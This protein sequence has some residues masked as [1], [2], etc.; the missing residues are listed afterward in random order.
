MSSPGLSPGLSLE[1]ATRLAAEA[2]R[3]ADGLGVHVSVVLLDAGGNDLLVSRHEQAYLSSPAIARRKAFTALNFRQPTHDMA[4]RLGSIEYAAQ[5]TLAE[6]RLAIIK[7][8]VPVLA[9]GRVVG[10]LG[11]SGGSGDQ[12]LE[13]A[14]TALARVP[15]S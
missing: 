11:V 14:E 8:G 6:P 13:I 5:I 2:H 12:D 15:L 3:V 4:E 1:T 7:G 10:G 9:D